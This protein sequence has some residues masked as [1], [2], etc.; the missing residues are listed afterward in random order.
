MAI[1][2]ILLVFGFMTLLGLVELKKIEMKERKRFA[3]RIKMR[4]GF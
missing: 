4:K 3:R 1:W 2:E